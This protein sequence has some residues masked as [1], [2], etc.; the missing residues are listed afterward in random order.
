MTHVKANYEFM[1]LG[2]LVLTSELHC[3]ILD[4]LPV[5]VLRQRRDGSPSTTY[6]HGFSVGFKGNYAGVCLSKQLLML[7]CACL[8]CLILSHL[9]CRVKRRSILSTT[10]WASEL[11]ITK[12]LRPTLPELLGLRLLQTGAIP[13]S[14]FSLFWSVCCI[15]LLNI[16]SWSSFSIGL[17]G[18]NAVMLLKVK[19]KKL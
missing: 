18:R 6:E 2:S 1:L 10:T 17:E 12:I 7:K 5:A 14:L 11:C 16:L 3:R 13:F 4:N 8:R 9:F 19:E 15:Y